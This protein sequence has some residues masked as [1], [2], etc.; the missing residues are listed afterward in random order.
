M[1]QTVTIGRTDRAGRNEVR[2]AARQRRAAPKR[3]AP[4]EWNLL[5]IVVGVIFLVPF[6]WLVVTALTKNGTLAVSF[7]GGLTTTNFTGLFGSNSGSEALGEGVGGAL[8]N[9]LYLSGG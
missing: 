7:S 5:A 6:I 3:K 2:L 8:L 4:W 9:S 1:A